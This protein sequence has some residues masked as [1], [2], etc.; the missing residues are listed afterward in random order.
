MLVESSVESIKAKQTGNFE[1][2]NI[3][4]IEFEEPS[5]IQNLNIG[6]FSAG[7]LAEIIIP[8]AIQKIESHDMYSI[9]HAYSLKRIVIPEESQHIQ[10]EL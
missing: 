3:N 9:A 5:S 10:W 1:S 7:T 8:T 6:I 4:T 2:L